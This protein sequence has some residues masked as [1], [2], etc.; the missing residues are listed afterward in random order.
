[1][2]EV[3]NSLFQAEGDVD[4]AVSTCAE[5]RKKSCGALHELE[6][7][8]SVKRIAKVSRNKYLRGVVKIFSASYRCRVDTLLRPKLFLHMISL[9][10]NAL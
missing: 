1:M 10:K 3:S 7:T 2:V 4:V 9:I 8:A 5:K 6:P